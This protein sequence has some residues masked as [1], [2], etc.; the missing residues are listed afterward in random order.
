MMETRRVYLSPN[1]QY[2]ELECRCCGKAAINAESLMKLERLREL[3]GGHPLHVASAYR[4]SRHNSAVG[5][6]LGS[7]HLSGKAFD[8]VSYTS[9]LMSDAAF[10]AMLLAGFK[11]IG[12][13][14]GKC[15][16]DDGHPRHTFWRYTD[17]GIER[18]TEAYRLAGGLMLTTHD[19]DAG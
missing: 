1:F 8:I 11:G 13:G 16:V 9:D 12:R 17:A 7:A 4:C 15:H 6:S 3:L 10:E 2:G 18:D 19:R 14:N 5:G